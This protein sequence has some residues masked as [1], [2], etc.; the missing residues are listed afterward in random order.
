MP[1]SAYKPGTILVV[2]GSQPGLGSGVWWAE[3]IFVSRPPHPLRPGEV[4]LILNRAERY[5]YLGG[6]CRYQWDAIL[7][8]K[9]VT[10]WAN[11]KDDGT[12]NVCKVPS[13]AKKSAKNKR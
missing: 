5:E 9:V 4:F 3:S 6:G 7:G 12:I 13:G 10:I 2:S 11:E 8:E 1:A